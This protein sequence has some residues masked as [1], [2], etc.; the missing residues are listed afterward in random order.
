VVSAL[1]LVC[2]PIIFY[3]V[4]RTERDSKRGA[5]ANPEKLAPSSIGFRCFQMT[6]SLLWACSE[7]VT[8]FVIGTASYWAYLCLMACDRPPPQRRASPLNALPQGAS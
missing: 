7:G 8:P 2:A 1:C 3:H 5:F 4:A 6:V